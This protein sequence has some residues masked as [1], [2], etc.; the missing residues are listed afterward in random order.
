MK[1]KDVSL[2]ILVTIACPL[3]YLL[4][5]LVNLMHRSNLRESEESRFPLSPV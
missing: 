4:V 2:L 3:C 1:K 5:L